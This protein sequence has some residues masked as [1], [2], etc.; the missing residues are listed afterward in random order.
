M[1]ARPAAIPALEK[2][3]EFI[4]NRMAEAVRRGIGK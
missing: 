1:A 2:S 4:I 3:R